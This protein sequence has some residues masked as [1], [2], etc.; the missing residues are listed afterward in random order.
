[1]HVIDHTC[2]PRDA[3]D[4]R[5]C[6]TVASQA[7]CGVPFEVRVLRLAPGAATPPGRCG[8]AQVVLVLAGSGKQRVDGGPQGFHAPCTVHVPA[9]AEHQIVNNGMTTLQLVV[10]AAPPNPA[11]PA[12]SP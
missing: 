6:Q 7:L 10:I 9:G 11:A 8:T 4:G 1:M 3:A 5:E 2:L 12:S